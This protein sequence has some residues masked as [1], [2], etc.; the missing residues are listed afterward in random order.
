MSSFQEYD[1]PILG[2][3]ID[4]DDEQIVIAGQAWHCVCG[5]LHTPEQVGLAET[6]IPSANSEQLF[7]FRGLPATEDERR[8]WI[9]EG[10]RN[11]AARRAG[12]QEAS[13]DE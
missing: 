6:V 4:L 7:I 5:Q 12:V 8:A 11:D 13:R 2:H 9:D 3:D 10:R 1:C